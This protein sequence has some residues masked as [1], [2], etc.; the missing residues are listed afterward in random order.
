M[1]RTRLKTETKLLKATT[2]ILNL[3]GYKEL[4]VQSITNKAGVSYGT[5]YNYFSSIEY[6]H[7]RVVKEKVYE[8]A[9]KLKAGGRGFQSPLNR[10]FF[11]WYLSLKLFAEDASAYWIIERPEIIHAAWQNAAE[12]MQEG[13]VIEAIKSGEIPGSEIDTLLHF[14]KARDTMRAGYVMVLQKILEGE[15]TE[16]AFFD[17]MTTLNLFNLEPEKIKSILNEVMQESQTIKTSL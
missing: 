16:K 8:V 2:D 14:R 17:Y 7:E 3:N 15:N 9:L 4:D 11:G 6:V 1:S 12:E 10:A 13:L 5:F